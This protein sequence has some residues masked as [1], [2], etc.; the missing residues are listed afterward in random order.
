MTAAPEGALAPDVQALAGQYPEYVAALSRNRRWNFGLNIL[1]SGTFALTKAAL[2]ETTVLPYFI[3]RLTANALVIGLSPSIAWFGLYM[4][5]LLGAYFVH[6][7]S[8]RKP[9][10]IALAW[11]ERLGILA[12]LLMALGIGRL[13]PGWVLAG[14]LAVYFV[15]WFI[16]GLFIPAYADFYSKH[17]PSGRGRFL[18]VQALL[19]GAIGVIGASVV[20]RLLL[21]APF[22]ANFVWV[23]A[24]A[25]VAA[26]PA[27]LAF[28]N[29]REVAFPVRRPRQTLAAY[30]QGTLPLL[31]G[32]PAFARFLAV[33]AVLVLGKMTVPFLAI[34]AL[35]R[36]HLGAG[37]VAVYTGL[38]LGAQSVSAPLWGLLCDRR[39]HQQVWLLAA[40]VQ[41][42]HAGLAWWA[43]SPGW[44]LVVFAL[45]G[46][47]LGAEAT[48]QPITT[49]LLS[50]AAET[51][52]FIGLANTCLGPLLAL[53]PLAGGALA[54][55]FSYPVALGASVGL[56][57]LGVG[58][59]VAWMNLARIPTPAVAA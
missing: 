21:A 42:L 40:V 8:R 50:P 1:D 35:Q 38:M 19:Y 23:L 6:N 9:Y 2:T 33:R 27:M 17:I 55:I 29:L 39:H 26:L 22:P 32:H 59:V 53:A 11:A 52:R 37:M 41:L 20:R 49:Y 12:M 43:P 13:P 30:F 46:V 47:T 36:F 31:R 51:T 3:S 58:A 24:F 4:P 34:Y 45:V 18:G 56:A 57:L 15:Y 54:N 28:H 44:Y 48:A 10:I 14:F 5:Q 16:S 25:L 7:L